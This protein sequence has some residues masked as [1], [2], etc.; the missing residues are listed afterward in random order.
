MS[1]NRLEHF[2]FF[3]EENGT[4]VPGILENVLNGRKKTTCE[5]K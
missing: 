2:E 1:V 4:Q 5:K 3:D